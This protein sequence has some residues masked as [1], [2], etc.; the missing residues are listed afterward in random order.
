MYGL[1]CKPQMHNSGSTHYKFYSFTAFLLLYYCFHFCQ[2]WY[3]SWG[4]LNRSNFTSRKSD[5][6]GRSSWKVRQETQDFRLPFRW[7]T[8]LLYKEQDCSKVKENV[9]ND[10]NCPLQSLFLICLALLPVSVELSSHVQKNFL[11]KQDLSFVERHPRW[12]VCFF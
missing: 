5:L 2:R 12:A 4:W 3:Q 1:F 8:G 9:K 11:T 10:G 7:N 6:R